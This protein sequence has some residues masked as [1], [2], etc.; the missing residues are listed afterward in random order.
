MRT[1]GLPD[2]QMIL[3]IGAYPETVALIFNDDGSVYDEAFTWET[4]QCAALHEGRVVLAV[5]NDGFM[6]AADIQRLCDYERA[7]YLDCFTNPLKEE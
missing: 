5:R 1:D 3:P 2:G 7:N 6:T 4:A